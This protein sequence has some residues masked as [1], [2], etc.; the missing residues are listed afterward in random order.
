[1]KDAMNVLAGMLVLLS[2]VLAAISAAGYAEPDKKGKAAFFAFV[3][4]CMPLFL[5]VIVISPMLS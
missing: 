2:P 5:I 1:M 3:W 4:T